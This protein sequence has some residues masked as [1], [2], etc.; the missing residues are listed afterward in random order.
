MKTILCL[1]FILILS[2]CSSAEPTPTAIPTPIPVPTIESIA[3]CED[4]SQENCADYVFNN[5]THPEG[6]IG[7][8]AFSA[9]NYRVTLIASDGMFVYFTDTEKKCGILSSVLSFGMRTAGEESSEWS[10][11]PNSGD[12]VAELLVSPTDTGIQWELRIKE[13]PPTED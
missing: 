3:I 11:W 10:L 7:E 4:I 1:M 13:L 6:E 8:V 12:C 5:Q 2:A 9:E